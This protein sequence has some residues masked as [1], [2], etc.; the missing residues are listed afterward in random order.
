MEINCRKYNF[1]IQNLAKDNLK[2]R[3]IRF[4]RLIMKLIIYKTKMFI[5]ENKVLKMKER[6]V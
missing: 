2:K 4:V 5:T 1:R 6:R 3:I